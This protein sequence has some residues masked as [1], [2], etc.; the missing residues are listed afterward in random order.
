MLARGLAVA[1]RAVAANDGDA[2][3]H[4]AVFCNLGRKLANEGASLAGVSDVERLR[5][6][7][8]RALALRAERSSTRSRR[9]V[10]SWSG[11]R[12]CSVATTTRASG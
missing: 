10:R 7:I 11:C 6:E 9:R 2:K 1:E 5:D 4:F 3:A 12:R 8:D